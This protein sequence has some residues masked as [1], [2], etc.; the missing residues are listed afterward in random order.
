MRFPTEQAL[1]MTALIVAMLAMATC[2]MPE[3]ECNV[4]HENAPF[5]KKCEVW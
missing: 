2:D 4:I 5:I 3:R 1:L